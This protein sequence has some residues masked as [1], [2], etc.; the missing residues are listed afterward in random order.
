MTTGYNNR[1]GS[2]MIEPPSLVEA[3]KHGFVDAGKR[4]ES[5][6]GNHAGRQDDN[7]IVGF[8]LGGIDER[9]VARFEW[10]AKD[11]A[12]NPAVEH[13]GQTEG[14][15]EKFSCPAAAPKDPY[16]QQHEHPRH[17]REDQCFEKLLEDE[18]APLIVQYLLLT[19]QR[20]SREE[21]RR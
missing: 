11:V 4:D 1:L 20:D 10:I 13:D 6:G 14:D 3:A 18:H 8:D 16:R 7:G 17:R 19:C 15:E 9:R 12:K 2:N 21:I 5:L